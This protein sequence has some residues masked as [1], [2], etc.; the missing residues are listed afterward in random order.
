VKRAALL[1]LLAFPAAAQQAE[2]LVDARAAELRGLDKIAGVSTDIPVSVGQT[3]ALGALKV[4]LKACR[5]P[6]DDPSSNAYA[7]VVISEPDGKVA[8][9]GWMIASSPALSALDHAR[10]DI[11]VVRC[12]TN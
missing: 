2:G 7:Y 9:D 4:T 12:S 5:Y 11:W 1:A 3:A 6:S 8:F 10:Y